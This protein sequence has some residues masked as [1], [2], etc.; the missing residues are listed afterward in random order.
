MIEMKLISP[1]RYR[2]SGLQCPRL[3]VGSK[4]TVMVLTIDSYISQDHFLAYSC[5]RR[6]IF[7][8]RKAFRPMRAGFP[9][10]SVSAALN[11]KPPMFCKQYRVAELREIGTVSSS[12]VWVGA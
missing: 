4:S 8:M 11:P 12:L 10:A 1:P 6:K 5:T 3:R 9:T 2:F 7:K